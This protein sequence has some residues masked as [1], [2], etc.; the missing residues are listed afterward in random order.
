M[1]HN[2]IEYGVMELI[3]E[4][5]DLMARGLGMKNDEMSRRFAQWNRGELNSYLIE[6]TAKVLAHVD[7]TT[8]DWLLNRIQDVAQQ[9]GTGVWTSMSALEL[10]CPVPVI[11]AA[12]A[13]R[14][15]STWKDKRELASRQLKWPHHFRGEREPF[16]MQLGNALYAAIIITYAQGMT[17]L[18]AAS[19]AFKYDLNLADV[20]RIWRGGCILRAALLEKIRVAYKA[21]P[22]LHSLLMD[23][24]FSAELMAR[25]NHLRNVVGKITH[26]GIPAFAFASSLSYFDAYRAERL[27]A[28]LIQAQRDFFGAHTYERTDQKGTFHTQWQ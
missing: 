5:Y 26:L 6:I 15:L 14:H 1:V 11:D 28:N 21:R 10:Q 16:L 17:L 27:P 4:T 7:P 2:G 13:M 23:P 22:D 8:G 19:R 25:Q 12:V 24:Q 18:A 3:A 20:A 9:K